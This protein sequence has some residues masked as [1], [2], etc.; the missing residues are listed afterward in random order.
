MFDGK[1]LNASCSSFAVNGVKVRKVE[2]SGSSGALSEACTSLNDAAA[3][4]VAAIIQL[5][6]SV[7]SQHSG[8]FYLL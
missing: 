1:C 3:T 8:S 5:L 6:R 7:L 4:A 2:T